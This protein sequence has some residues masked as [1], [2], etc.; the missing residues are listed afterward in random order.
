MTPSPFSDWA[1]VIGIWDYPDLG[2]LGG[3]EN[4]ARAFAAWVQSPTGGGVPAERVRLVLSSGFE[5]AE[6]ASRAQPAPGHIEALFDELDDLAQASS[7]RGEGLRVG[8]R[9]YLYFAGHGCA[10]LLDE[11]V[12][13][14]ANATRRRAGY[15]IPGKPW[16]NWF[17]RAGYFDEILLFMDCCRESYPQ[18]PLNVPAYIDV[19]APDAVERG[20]RFY[21]FGTKWSR[22]SRERQMAD[23]T[24]RGVF[25]SALMKGLEGAAAEPDGRITASSLAGYL[26][27]GM[28]GFLSEGDLEDPLIPK[29]PD[30]E[31]HPAV[32]P[33][34]V[35][36]TA[37]AS[38]SVSFEVQPTPAR[39][40]AARLRV[41]A[42]DAATEI[43][44]VDDLHHIV[45]EGVGTLERELAPEN[46]RVTVR[47]GEVTEEQPV[48]LRSGEE[49]TQEFPRLPFASPAPLAET[50]FA[51]ER[52]V[53]AAIEQSQRVHVRAGQGSQ[54][55]LLARRV[56]APGRDA[57]GEESDPARGL[58]LTDAAGEPIADLAAESWRDPTGDAVA[59][60]T[61]EVDPGVYRLSGDGPGGQ[62]LEQ[63]VVASEG[64]QT[65]VCLLQRGDQV[66]LNGAAILMAELGERARFDPARTEARLTE[67][68][69]LGLEN[70][71]QVVSD[72]LREMVG[73]SE[74]NPMLG[75]LCAHLLLLE[76]EPNLA[77]VETI[78]ANLRRRIG[79][80]PHPDV[81]ALAVRLG[82]G[83]EQQVFW[84][85]PMLR[86]SW[87]LVVQATVDRPELVPAGSPA[88]AMADRIWGSGPW[89]AWLSADTGGDV[90]FGLP[91][92]GRV[93]ATSESF[94][95][96]LIRQLGTDART[97]SPDVDFSIGAESRERVQPDEATLRRLVT[98]LGLPRARVEEM[99]ANSP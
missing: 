58:V 74:V 7:G 35:I 83:A 31:M 23:G 78:V 48:L 94:E 99:L 69:R 43:L 71:R 66:D 89:L 34:F 40:A 92:T 86:R 21:A 11:S 18:A 72:E 90:A 29:T 2:D 88:A 25:T 26:F 49:V 73:R 96:A 77:L 3:P 62:P 64:W 98:T 68:A 15:H 57:G 22:L 14:T 52:H 54:I 53:A 95:A 28:K 45:A 30:I 55:F 32:D 59:A 16:A 67:L 84:S 10:P 80:A 5:T 20:R 4:D 39:E 41:R 1:I 13:L 91:T 38:P 93:A 37:P 75:I 33:E 70:R 60:C 12:L 63:I 19:T 46:Y 56:S 82:Q 81:E 36:V 47:A 79:S 76:P 65:Q 9:L 44:V 42:G 97:I 87:E 50:A 17:Y 8:R 51:D 27:T 24:V 85:P 6:S 61:I